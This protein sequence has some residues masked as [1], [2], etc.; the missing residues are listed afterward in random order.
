MNE[1]YITVKQ[2]AEILNVNPETL[3]RWDNRGILKAKR[4]TINNYRVYDI[5]DIEKFKKEIIK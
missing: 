3:R 5:K 1:Q 4:N 2:A